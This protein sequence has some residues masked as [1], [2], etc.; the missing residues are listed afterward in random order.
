MSLRATSLRQN[1]FGKDYSS[2]S[3]GL[4]GAAG[5]MAAAGRRHAVVWIRTT[6]RQGTPP[7]IPCFCR[8]TAD[9]PVHVGKPARCT[10]ARHPVYTPSVVP[11]VPRYSSA[12]AI[13]CRAPNAFPNREGKAEHEALRGHVRSFHSNGLAFECSGVGV[14]GFPRINTVHKHWPMK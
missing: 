13:F 7:A 8:K 4:G 5:A 6:A 10:T 11:Q 12:S 9:D 3:S 2:S 1:L 14:A